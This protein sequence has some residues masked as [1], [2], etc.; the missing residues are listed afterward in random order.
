MKIFLI[1]R[2]WPSS[3]RS[4]V[5]FIAAQHAKILIESGYDIMILGADKR[6]LNEK[7]NATQKFY[8]KARGSGSFYSPSFVD[9]K[10]LINIFKKEKPDLVIVESWQTAITDTSIDVAHS[11][12]I[13]VVMISHGVSVHP[14]VKNF[15]EA[16]RGLCWSLY[17]IYRLPRLISKL[18]LITVLDLDSK[19]NRFYD[20]NLAFRQHIPVRLLVNSPVNYSTNINPLKNRNCQILLLGYF[21]RIKNQFFAIKLLEKLSDKVNLIFIGKRKGNYYKACVKYVQKHGLESRIKFL[22]DDECDISAE[23]SLTRVVLLS[24]ITEVLPLTLIEAMASG[25]PFVAKNVGA[26]SSL[27][28]GILVNHDDEFF[29]AVNNL[30]EDDVLWQDLSDQGLKE[31]RARYSE[32]VIK[33]NLLSLIEFISKKK[34]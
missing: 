32:N 27:K 12:G 8:V 7:I 31:F 22:E 10:C 26:I 30:L 21:S 24:S 6:I 11:L 5:S 29:E 2:G 25:T 17:K 34:R 13:P 16:I 15:S 23:I 18:T 14:F 4:G 28:S 1:S 33:K 9:K 19:S 3:D 20:R